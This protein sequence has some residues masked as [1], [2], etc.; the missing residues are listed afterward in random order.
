M[1]VFIKVFYSATLGADVYY[2]L[3]FF[4]LLLQLLILIIKLPST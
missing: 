4:V 3:S 1:H 2:L